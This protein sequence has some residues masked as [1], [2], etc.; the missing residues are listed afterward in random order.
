MLEVYKERIYDLLNDQR[1]NLSI[2]E[3]LTKG[4]Y[5]DGLSKMVLS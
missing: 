4:I 3:S 1:E 2:K 5:V